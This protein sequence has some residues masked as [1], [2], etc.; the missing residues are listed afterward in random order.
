MKTSILASILAFFAAA[1][2]AATSFS[3]QGCLR[4]ANGNVLTD[5]N[6]TITFKLYKT[7]TGD[8]VLWSNEIAVLLDEEGIFNVEL[9]DGAGSTAPETHLDDVLADNANGTLY[10]GLTVSG[11]SGEIRPRQKILPVPVA[12]F[13]QNVAKADGDFTV[14]GV[15]TLTGAVNVESGVTIQSRAVVRS[16][17]VEDGAVIT[18]DTTV[19]GSLSLS[20][21]DVGLALAAGTPFTIGGVN[22]A[23]PKG[24]I[25]MWSGSAADIPAGWALCDGNSGR[26]DLRG[27]FILGAGTPGNRSLSD[28]YSAAGI[29]LAER[30]SGG[31]VRHALTEKEMPKHSHGMT[32]YGADL[33]AGW[34]DDNYF[35]TTWPKYSKNSN[36]CS[37]T[38]AGGGQPHNNMPPFYTLCFI[39]KL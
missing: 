26:P 24:V 8:E 25:V 21:E 14:S 37:T 28:Q 5:R 29:A 23:I 2:T 1:A 36:N 17:T 12:S 33:D 13:A 15:T 9:S 20:D 16:L 18:G 19:N 11:S 38:E 27:R 31:E 39:I 35:Y 7:P 30:N 3:Y 34:D 10:I 22:A 4:D 32:F 6:Q